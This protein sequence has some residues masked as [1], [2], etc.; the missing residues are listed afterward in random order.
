MPARRGRRSRRRERGRAPPLAPRA[1][2]GA[3]SPARARCG[4]GA[5]VGVAAAAGLAGGHTAGEALLDELLRDGRITANA[6]RL[7]R[8]VEDLG[9]VAGLDDV[10][11]GEVADPRAG[12]ARGGPDEGVVDL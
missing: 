10:A 11:V 2:G 3:C 1:G 4:L 9:V 5:G 8:R 12:E 7:A 6:E